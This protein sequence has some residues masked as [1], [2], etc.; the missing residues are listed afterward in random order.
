MEKTCKHCNEPNRDISKFCSK[1]GKALEAYCVPG[2]LEIGTVLENR[3]KIITKLHE[4]DMSAIYKARVIKLNSVC[5]VKELVPIDKA[6]HE[7]A[8][9]VDWFKREAKLLGK[10]DH[11]SIPKVFDY[12][13]HNNQYYLVMNFIE[14]TTLLDILERNGDP[15]LPE[16]QVVEWA[17][18]ILEVFKY[19][20]SQDPPV[21]YRDLK[22]SNIMIHKDGRVM[23]ID[24]GIARIVRTEQDD[25]APK[26]VIG[27]DGYAPLEQYKGKP[28]S[29]SDLYALGATMHHLLTG[30]VP[31]PL[32]IDPVSEIFPSVTPE[33]DEFIKKAVEEKPENRFANAEEMLVALKNIE[34]IKDRKKTIFTSNI[35][36]SLYKDILFEKGLRKLHFTDTDT[37]WAVGDYGTIL[38]FD[39]ERWEKIK[40]RTYER[41]YSLHFID[42][43]KGWIAGNK[44][45]ILYTTDGGKNWNIEKNSIKS[46]IYGIYFIDKNRGWIVGEKG[47]IFYTENG[48]ITPWYKHLIGGSKTW[49]KQDSGITTALYDVHFT[50]ENNGWIVGEF[51]TILYTKDGGNI[52]KKKDTLRGLLAINFPDKEKGWAV[53]EMGTILHTDDG[54]NTWNSQDSGTKAYLTDLHFIN[55]KNGWAVGGNLENGATILCTDDGG[56]TWSKQECGVLTPLMGIYFSDENNGWITGYNGIIL[57]TKNGG[58]NWEIQEI[59]D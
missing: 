57:H 36:E 14:G 55:Q 43:D 12:F 18:Q 33:L 49:K 24:F 46:N 50:D 30:V 47:L 48:G 15:G 41:L 56:N 35:W 2:T 27:T 34:A 26:T 11:A 3:Y 29:R 22:P 58:K 20:H 4:S 21:I 59:E 6:V 39:G 5:A 53:G 25:D 31:S 42:S 37:G 40:N 7:S 13:L 16:E 28:E 17:K 51:G 54:G 19:L 23:L 38:E 10:L 8:Q 44:G 52:W 45:T 1:C 9:A 32:A